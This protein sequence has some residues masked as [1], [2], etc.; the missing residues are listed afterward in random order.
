MN[1]LRSEIVAFLA[2]LRGRG[3]SIWP[4]GDLLNIWPATQLTAAELERLRANKPAV[5]DYLRQ[6]NADLLPSDEACRELRRKY[7]NTQQPS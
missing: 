2:E 3:V 1:S 5:L 4:D 6:R 7:C